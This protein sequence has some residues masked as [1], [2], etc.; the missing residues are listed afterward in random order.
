M[1]VQLVVAAVG[2]ALA[3]S[4]RS[5]LPL[6]FLL[7]VIACSHKVVVGMFI[8]DLVDEDRVFHRRAASQSAFFF[9]LRSLFTV[10]ADSAVPVA[11]VHALTRLGIDPANMAVEGAGKE[12]QLLA[13]W[14]GVPLALAIVKLVCS[15][16]FT[17]KGAHLDRVREQRAALAKNALAQKLK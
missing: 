14:W 2:G 13:L 17:L 16:H 1:V 6:L 7:N 9:S 15:A 5:A 10:W 3:Y 12:L 8:A 4:M 11:V